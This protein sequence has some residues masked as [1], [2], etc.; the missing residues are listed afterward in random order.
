[1]A[2]NNQSL[3]F[4]LRSCFLRYPEKTNKCCSLIKKESPTNNVIHHHFHNEQSTV[5]NC[6]VLLPHFLSFSFEICIIFE[7]ISFFYFINTLSKNTSH[8]NIDNAYFSKLLTP[9]FQRH[10]HTLCFFS[11]NG[12]G[13]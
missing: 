9:I 3:Y 1:M 4:S 8:I 11:L 10:Q 13:R 7:K 2:L 12:N 5:A 6:V